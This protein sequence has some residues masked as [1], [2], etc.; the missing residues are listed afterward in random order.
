MRY[1]AALLLTLITFTT[2]AAEAQARQAPP[3]ET[4]AAAQ[5]GT[6]VIRG[7]VVAGESGRP[8]RRARV[9]LQ[10][11]GLG[12]DGV[13]STS[14]GPDGTFVIKD[15]PAARYRVDV[16]RSGYLKIDY[17]QRRPALPLK[18]VITK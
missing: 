18:V 11:I 5:K 3:R 9:N 8:P 10:G 14:T 7:R 2:A 12:R 15:L 16:T 6:G 4:S 1:P 13:R 17:G